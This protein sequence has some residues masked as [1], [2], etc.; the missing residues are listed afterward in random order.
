MG[1]SCPR[2]GLPGW[3]E[4]PV[5][6]SPIPA[7]QSASRRSP[8]PATFTIA[9]TIVRIEADGI[10]PGGL[11]VDDRGDIRWSD[12][13]S[14]QRATRRRVRLPHRRLGGQRARAPLPRPDPA[15]LTEPTSTLPLQPRSFERRSARDVRAPSRVVH[16]RH[17]PSSP[18]DDG[19]TVALGRAPCSISD[20]ELIPTSSPHGRQLCRDRRR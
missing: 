11:T 1:R 12:R 9:G 14:L 4:V 8:K 6:C 13:A 15:L 18:T 5:S 19:L 20:T 2:R 3:Q 17:R 7:E 10:A 16:H